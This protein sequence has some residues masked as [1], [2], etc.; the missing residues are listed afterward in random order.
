MLSGVSNW[1]ICDIEKYV[2]VV[3]KINMRIRS[4]LVRGAA[5]LRNRIVATLP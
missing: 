3:L 4:V 1:G 5:W 2:L